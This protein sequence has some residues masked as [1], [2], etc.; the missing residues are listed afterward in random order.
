MNYS[1]IQSK[2]TA[3]KARRA[4]RRAKAKTLWGAVSR[5]AVRQQLWDAFAMFIKIR[6]KRKYG[7]LCLICGKRPI[8]VAYHIVPAQRGDSTR[9]D[10]LNVVGAC[11][12]CNCGEQWH[13]SLY[14]EKHCQIFGRDTIEALEDKA[15]EV[16]QLSTA[17]L[18][19]L[20]DKYRGLLAGGRP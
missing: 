13:R 5:S 15:R 10:E 17:E 1:E 9:Y 12:P 7:G 20:R 19:A 14:R 4:K 3:A 8:Q 16:V 6:D 11:A 2:L 18:V